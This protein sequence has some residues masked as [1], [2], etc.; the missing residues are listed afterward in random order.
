[1]KTKLIFDFTL[2]WC[3]YVKSQPKLW[4]V[5]ILVAI[6]LSL[7]FSLK[8]YRDNYV[9][10]SFLGV[11]NVKNLSQVYISS[12]NINSPLDEAILNEI[13]TN[14][15][16]LKSIAEKQ[17]YFKAQL[18]SGVDEK[19][20]NVSFFS[21]GY[22]HL[23]I[24]PFK[25]SFEAMEFPLKGGDVVAAISYSFW[26]ESL[27]AQSV[28][29]TPILINGVTVKVV[30]ILPPSFLSL[31]KNTVVDIV[32]PYTFKGLFSGSETFTPDTQTYLI[33]A[34]QSDIEEALSA[35]RPDLI[36]NFF[37]FDDSELNVIRGFGIDPSDYV[38]TME[39]VDLTTAVFFSLLFFCSISFVGFMLGELVKKQQEYQIRMM[40]GATKKTINLQRKTE[41][42]LLALLVVFSMLLFQPIS[43]FI[44]FCFFYAEGE[45]P[46]IS[47]NFYFLSLMWFC[48][49]SILLF[50]NFSQ[51]KYIK[52]YLGRSASLTL[53]QRLQGYGLL[54]VLIGVTV[55][56]IS[57]S[58][59]VINGQIKLSKV[60]YGF[61]YIDRWVIN[62]TNE[63]K[64]QTRFEYSKKPQ[65]IVYEIKQLEQVSNV[66][67]V[68]VAPLEGKKSF[69]QW[70][71]P[72]GVSIGM[73]KQTS[74]AT[75]RV[76]PEYFSI[77]NTKIL[78]GYNIQKGK[79]GS[80]V[81]N[82][83][84]WNKYFKNEK[85][86]SAYL[87][88]R[89]QGKESKYKVIGIVEDI[90]YEGPDSKPYPVVYEL[91]W[92]LSGTESIVIQSRYFNID[93]VTLKLSSIDNNYKIKKLVSLEELVD[94]ESKPRKSILYLTLFIS[95]ILFFSSLLFCSSLVNQL[96][97]KLALELNLKFS[98]GA[99]LS[100]LFLNLYLPFFYSLLI[101]SFLFYLFLYHCTGFILPE[102]YG[103]LIYG[104]EVFFVSSFVFMSVIIG[105]LFY[106]ELKLRLNNGWYYLS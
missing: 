38:K 42:A 98:F 7:I 79:L 56:S 53:S 83:A 57:I 10:P 39:R 35:I 21:G 30:A 58:C 88:R 6:P 18:F 15:P 20:I 14:F 17:Q 25:G 12:E 90:H 37:I 78:A 5:T 8:N 75:H 67:L 23:E 4:L 68:S 103:Y 29:N 94:D 106:K 96:V 47:S 70:F 64:T 82:Q 36:N 100:C 28:L 9:S 84:L 91:L 52:S 45:Y 72:S 32:V 43:S 11:D 19:L 22:S 81:V 77:L 76:T 24:K 3:N 95:V 40:S 74:T 65:Q 99:S 86:S 44:I 54:V 69:S 89:D 55:I 101:F 27:N 59:S 16:N 33:G 85:L 97:E 13:E 49:F 34:N 50:I 60:S 66:A 26:K 71:T 105:C 73:T 46:E 61:D 2:N 87:I 31:R 41:S 104:G 92:A 93:D 63:N 102:V 1:M 51:E 80:L 62:L 48:F